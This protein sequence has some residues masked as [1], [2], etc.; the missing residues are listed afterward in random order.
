MM[1]RGISHTRWMNNE[2]DSYTCLMPNGRILAPVPR[3]S[4]G[5]FGENFPSCL[6]SSV[7]VPSWFEVMMRL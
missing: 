4:G 3:N 6:L 5:K 7:V 1:M 2:S